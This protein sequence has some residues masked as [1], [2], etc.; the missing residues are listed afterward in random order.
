[1]TYNENDEMLEFNNNKKLMKKNYQKYLP[2]DVQIEDDKL[3]EKIEQEAKKPLPLL[4]DILP[5]LTSFQKTS[6]I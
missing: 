5:S 6:C 1:M 3:N 2:A 4:S